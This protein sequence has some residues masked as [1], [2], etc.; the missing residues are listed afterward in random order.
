M[1][2]S[3]E[4]KCWGS[5]EDPDKAFK[6]ASADEAKLQWLNL[7]QW[8]EDYVHCFEEGSVWVTPANEPRQPE[9]PFALE[10][11]YADQSQ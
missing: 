7:H 2:Y 6:F 4:R 5:T 11:R 3:G 9:L 8:P 10:C 1:Y